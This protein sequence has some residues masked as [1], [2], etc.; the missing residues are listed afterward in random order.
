MEERAVTFGVCEGE[1]P[2]RVDNVPAM[3]CCQCGEKVFGPEAMR[4]MGMIRDGKPNPMA[5]RS[6]YVYDYEKA[7]A[8]LFPQRKWEKETV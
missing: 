7:R 1:W 6:L 3:E 2:V 4:V 8:A 5:I